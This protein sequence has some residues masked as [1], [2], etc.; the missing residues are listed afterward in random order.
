MKEEEY[1]LNSDQSYYKR[2]IHTA[3]F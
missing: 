1:N 2:W 3:V